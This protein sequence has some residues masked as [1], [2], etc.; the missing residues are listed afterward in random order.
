[1]ALSGLLAAGP[2]FTVTQMHSA[3]ALILCEM[4]PSNTP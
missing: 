3:L 1:M 2:Y 4:L